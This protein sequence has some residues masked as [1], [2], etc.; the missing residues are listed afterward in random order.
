MNDQLQQKIHNEILPSRGEGPVY[1]SPENQRRRFLSAVSKEYERKTFRTFRTATLT[2]GLTATVVAFIALVINTRTYDNEIIFHVGN[3]S[4]MGNAGDFVESEKSNPAIIKF[5]G[6][7]IYS[8]EKG[9]S[10]RVIQSNTKKVIVDLSEGK[11][12]C[13]VTGNGHTDWII[14]AGTYEVKVTGTRFSVLWRPSEKQLD[15]N[16][17]KGSV[18][19]TGARL[20]RHGVRL[21]A[22]D[23]LQVK[24]DQI[25]ISPYNHTKSNGSKKPYNKESL[26]NP[27][28]SANI[29]SINKG[30]KQ[31]T[32]KTAF[33]ENR[34]VIHQSSTKKSNSILETWKERYEAK[35]YEGAITL[36]TAHNF[37]QLLLKSSADDLTKLGNAA[38]YSRK[39]DIAVQILKTIQTRFI[40]S[41][42]ANNA[43]FLLGR[44]ALELQHNPKA[45]ALLFEQYL[46]ASP[47]GPLSDESLGRLI[48]IYKNTGNIPK[49][50]KAA[51]AYIQ[52]YP[53]GS[54]ASMA[55]SVL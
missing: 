8:L 4:L 50:K 5:D 26:I 31:L 6:G 19:V 27:D 13:K 7:T 2:I 20:N 21:M 46:H 54:F 24:M 17:F 38:R 29:D 35:D 16:V 34:A 45:A 10:A 36:A 52:K 48:E 49:A 3:N 12:S 44:V 25:T 42:R 51:N 33:S 53:D 39:T 15:V 22:G 28:I 32:N 11:I 55:H 40:G 30:E 1:A 9:S 14:R 37:D 43:T 23:Q 18:Q 41:Y 47:E